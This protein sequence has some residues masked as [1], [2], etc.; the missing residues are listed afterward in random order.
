M[1]VEFGDCRSAWSR[2]GMGDTGDLLEMMTL[3]W[4]LKGERT[5]VSLSVPAQAWE[6]KSRICDPC[7]SL[8]IPLVMK[9][10]LVEL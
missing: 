5:F 2:S 6:I 7:S 4:V 1:V 8:T 9:R 3:T 10:L